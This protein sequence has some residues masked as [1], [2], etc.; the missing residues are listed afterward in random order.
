[1]IQDYSRGFCPVKKIKEFFIKLKNRFLTWL[2]DIKAAVK[3]FISFFMVCLSVFLIFR[4]CSSQKPYKQASA[5]SES[6]FESSSSAYPLDRSYYSSIVISDNSFPRLY[7]N[8]GFRF[9]PAPVFTIVDNRL[10]INCSGTVYSFSSEGTFPLLSF[11]YVSY[12]SKG[13]QLFEYGAG[14]LTLISTVKDEPLVGILWANLVENSTKMY[15]VITR[16]G[17][18]CFAS[19]SSNR[20]RYNFFHDDDLLF[21]AEFSFPVPADSAR[22]YSSASVTLGSEYIYNITRVVSPWNTYSSGYREGYEYGY[23]KADERYNVGYKAGY[24]NGLKESLGSIT[25]WDV[26]FHAVN[27]FF[28]AKLFGNISILNIIM[29]CFGLILLGIVIKVFLGG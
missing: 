14:T 8:S 10:D 15:N 28:N 16:L 2:P 29:L 17:F 18:S 22:E 1:M 6:S 3:P 5:A 24:D 25:P 7:I 19:T 4:S 9:F 20:I 11:P 27:S 23:K 21:I 26:L 13:N 12:D